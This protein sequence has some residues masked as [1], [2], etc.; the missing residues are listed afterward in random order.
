VIEYAVPFDRV[1]THGLGSYPVVV[2]RF[3]E[4]VK[5][6]LVEVVVD[7]NVDRVGNEGKSLRAVIYLPMSGTKSKGLSPL[8]KIGIL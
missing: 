2:V 6:S 4:G 8:M 3:L 7:L 1:R 5:G